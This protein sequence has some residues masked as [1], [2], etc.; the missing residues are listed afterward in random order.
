MSYKKIKR[1]KKKPAKQQAAIAI[2]KKAKG[3]Y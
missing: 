1:I 3:G 2:A